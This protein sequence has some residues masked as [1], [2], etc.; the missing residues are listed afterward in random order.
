MNAAFLVVD[1]PPGITSHDVVAAVRAVTG[2][3]KVGHTGTLDPFATGV[4][5]LALG[6]ATRLIQYLDESI[7]V[8]DATIAL[9]QEMD[10]GDPTG[11]VIREAAVP[12]LDAVDLEGVLAGFLG[13]RMQVPPA[14][15]AVKKDGKPLY[16]YARRGEA[17]E[18]AARPITLH[19]VQ[20]VEVGPASLRILLTCSRGTYARVLASEIAEALGTVGHL[21]A[22][23]RARSGPFHLAHAVSM[24]E[25]GEWVSA[26]P[27][28]PWQDVL[29][30]RGRGAPRL[31]WRHRDE[32]LGALAPRLIR[33]V[34]AL[35][36]LPLADADRA[37]VARL[38]A[39]GPPPPPPPG[40]LVGGRYLVAHGDDLVAVAERG[41]R[42]PE[43][44]RVVGAP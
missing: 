23:S 5:P 43:A 37:A 44:V 39:G 3:Q 35:S 27:G 19:E 17:V 33:P 18:V 31:P 26:E 1:K 9:G 15:S 30:A 2:I 32:V 25:I 4:L 42:G 22:L 29:L 8:Y 6:A 34:D 13:E 21:S 40:V 14:Y 28:H 20:V 36:H 7:K 16:H 38:R 41:P 10:T 24:P 11:A 12:D